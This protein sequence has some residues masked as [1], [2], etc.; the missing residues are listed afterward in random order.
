MKLSRPFA[1][2]PLCFDVQR[3]QA[4][5]ALFGE[6]EWQRHPTGF[7]GNSAI[8]LITH[9]GEETDRF[10]SPM[11]PTSQLLRTPYIRQ[12]LAHFGVVW[13]RSRLMRL[14][15]GATVPAHS[16][17]NYHWYRRVRIHIP[18]FT[19]P[20]VRFSCG[21]Q[22]VHMGAGEVWVF[23]NWATHEVVN[24]GA[25]DRIHL[26]AD[27]C[28]T[29]AF[30]HSVMTAQSEGFDTWP[31]GRPEPMPYRP[32]VEAQLVFES[33]P[34][35]VVMPPAEVEQ[36]VSDLLADLSDPTSA[37][38]V[39]ELTQISALARAFCFDWRALWTIFGDARQ[40]W[41]EFAKLR[42]DAT[43]KLI[44]M[45][46]RLVCASNGAQ[47]AEVM[48]A[49]V[50][51]YAFVP[52]GQRDWALQREGDRALSNTALAKHAAAP[53]RAGNT[54]R[55][56]PE[57]ERLW[58]DRPIFIVAAPRSGS[59]ALFETL[60]QVPGIMTAGGETPGLIE[61]HPELRPSALGVGS[62]RLLARHATP[63]LRD[64]ILGE[65][66]SMLRDRDGQSIGAKNIRWLEKT[67]KNALRIPFF[68][69]LFPDAVFI[70]LWRDPRENI[71][72]IIDAWQ[73]GS[74]VTYPELTGWD[75]PWSML[76]PPGWDGMRGRPV[77]EIAAFQW[78]ETNRIICDDLAQLQSD[79]HMR[80]SYADF[81]N[82]PTTVIRKI[83]AFAN[84]Q[85]DD[86]VAAYLN[87]PLPM[88][89]YTLMPP[90]PDKWRHNEPL[91]KNL[92]PAVDRVAM[93]LG[94]TQSRIADDVG[95]I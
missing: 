7:N 42:D 30:W 44:R 37:Q 54:A 67:P 55:K 9:K 22:T 72:S 33:A 87:K 29:A 6:A 75:G 93:H 91:L 82:S 12:I 10:G 79:R 89:K 34:M 48:N 64:Q 49:R 74:W 73:S 52:P 94:F 92:L 41:D 28:G 8:R 20:K 80:V 31:G 62:N 61:R 85:L 70:H 45:N 11:L 1:R 81:T 2:L 4:E 15:P 84:L 77:A 43:A 51:E 71:S 26:V 90:H 76:L 38:D 50:L 23:D 5:V 58:L 60:A 27:T 25:S 88:S 95:G 69:A 46:L 40:G 39:N 24:A 13:S 59:T 32:A 19:E 57:A 86:R 17:I 21:G 68:D 78:M 3:L 83:A 18:I 16:D 63:A 65:L 66:A 36:L 56:T 47:V 14:A 53:G 35:H